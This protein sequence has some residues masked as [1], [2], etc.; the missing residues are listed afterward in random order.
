MR[1]SWSLT[2]SMLAAA[3]A[4][5]STLVASSANSL[6]SQ[7]DTTRNGSASTTAIVLGVGSPVIDAERSGTSIGIVA[8]GRLYVFDAGPGVERRIME[9]GPKLKVLHVTTFGP[10]FISHLHP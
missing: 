2:F 3:F 4:V 8:D 10:V 7:T 9:A 5:T 6:L 1:S